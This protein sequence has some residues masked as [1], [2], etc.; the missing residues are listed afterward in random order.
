LYFG[1]GASRR[2][3]QSYVVCLDA[4]SGDQVWRTPVP[5]PAW[6][7]PVVAGDKVFVGTGNGRLHEPAKPPETP[8]GAMSCF[9]AK[10]GE[11]VWTFPVPDA[12]FTQPVVAADRVVFGCR[13]AHLYAVSLDGKERFSVPMGGPVMASPTLDGGDV[14]AV[15]VRGRIVCV[16]PADGRPRWQHELTSR[17][18][19]VFAPPRVAGRRLFVAAETKAGSVGVVSLSCFEMPE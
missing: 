7:P 1:S 14:I 16:N 13:D 6:G 12:V 4:K 11:Q 15:S 19:L 9:D 10:T 5:L 8:A 3:K 18:A 2:F 17:E